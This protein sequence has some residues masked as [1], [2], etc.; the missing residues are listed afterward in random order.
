MKKIKENTHKNTYIIIPSP[1][2]HY[3]SQFCLI[4]KFKKEK[5]KYTHKMYL[6]ILCFFLSDKIN[7]KHEDM[8]HLSRFFNYKMVDILVLRFSAHFLDCI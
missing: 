5:K 3:N 2:M 6:P 4:P 1:N 7:D 8:E